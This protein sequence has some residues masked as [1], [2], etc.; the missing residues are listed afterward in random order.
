MGIYTGQILKGTKPADLP[1]T[2]SMKFELVSLPYIANH[3][4]AAIAASDVGKLALEGRS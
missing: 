2:R 4:L 3:A 1:V